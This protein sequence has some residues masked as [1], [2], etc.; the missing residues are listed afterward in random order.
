MDHKL[1]SINSDCLFLIDGSSYLYRAY[2]AIRQPLTTHKGLPTKA[3]LGV[4]NMLW[5]V[6][7]EK[8]PKYVAMIWDAKGPTF[9][10][11]LYPEYKAN[12][13][14]MPDD[15][16]IQIPYVRKV[17]D[18]LGIAQL[19]KE[20]YEADDIIATL[21]TRLK[22]Q[23][24]LIVSGDKDLL[25]LVSPMV[26]IW[27]P[28]KDERIDLDTFKERFHIAPEKLLDVMALSGDTS[29][30]IPGVPGI[31]PK[32]ALK[33]IQKYGSLEALFEHVDEIKGKT[34]ERIRENM[35][36]IQLW[37]RLVS[38][39]RQVEVPSDINQFV[40]RPPDQR[41]LR[42]IFQELEFTRFLKEMLPEK[43]I[44]FEDYELV[45]S[46]ESLSRWAEKIK[47]NGEVVID[48]ETTSEFAMRARL[49]GISLCVT[50]P[51]ACYIPVG[52]QTNEPQLSLEE[53]AQVLG[54]IFADPAI[55]KTG[56]NIKYDLIVLKK[57]ALDLN[58]VSGDTMIASYLLN[59][60]KRQHN[61]AQIAQEVLGH[62]MISF[63]EV[64][65]NRSKANNFA[66][67]E[68]ARARDYSCE[69]VHVTSLV[70][71]VLWQRLKESGLWEL[72]HQVEV[73]LIDVLA[74][75]E[76]HGIL[77][78]TNGLNQ[79]SEEF[80]HS[81]NKL[82]NEIYTV[83]GQHFNINSPK[84][85]AEILFEKLKLPQIKK[86]KKKTGYSTDMEVLSELSKQHVLPGLIVRYRNLAKLNSTYV[87]GLRRMVHPETGRIHTSFNQTVTATGRLS[88][89]DPNL[90]NIPVRSKEGR[91]I[92]ALF[93][94]E[95]GKLL[96][97]AD[98]SQIDLRVLAHY[99]G[100]KTLIEAFKRGEDIHTRTAAEVF[101]TSQDL[102]TPDMR[103]AAKTVNFGI[104]YGMS[105]YGLAKE[106]GIDRKEAKDFITRYFNRYPGVKRYMDEI[107]KSAREKGYVTTILGRRRYIPDL[108]SRTRAVR[109]FAERTAI[110]TPIQG[111]AAD[112]IKLAMLRVDK[113]LTEMECDSA[114]VL[115]VHDELVL[116][117]RKDE[118][119]KV[120]NMVKET[121]ETVV[122]LAVPLTVNIGWGKDWANLKGV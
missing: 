32:T 80:S 52:H 30:N 29:D 93:V 51:H 88:S 77:V 84:Q 16:S 40:R 12:R 61:L 119:E 21:V 45:Q 41:L 15:L 55:A 79:L 112:I 13:P 34:G 82:E 19:E 92:R 1:N 56:Q 57:H 37:K 35:D 48:T 89:S 65:A 26:T 111:S 8:D 18:A 69:D 67:V 94:A 78:D 2:F 53:V 120:A 83:A 44:S 23:N 28:M 101:D 105:A 109:E 38:L 20:G 103:R 72:F 31:G 70:K 22:D 10:H 27:D 71:E 114:L 33:L 107:V 58:G 54:G 81:L 59:P 36:R 6:L 106:L 11:D 118:L 102:V 96:L 75:M 116:E 3:I 91:R 85:L 110:N 73:P 63:K 24:I 68:L 87:D 117:V 121:M 76:M 60:T 46:K 98:Y 9:R 97:S 7:R 39:S 90:Q 99:S 4:T 25:Q 17:V 62:K 14:E 115:Q 47:K 74:K 100:D 104:I 42:N 50:P 49:V 122:E 113:N 66:S 64:T 5:K 43:T 86:T 95:E 108:R